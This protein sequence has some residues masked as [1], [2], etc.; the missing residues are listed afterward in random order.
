[1][2]NNRS[3]FSD[4]YLRELVRGDPHWNDMLA[5]VVALRQR[6]AE[7]YKRGTPG[8]EQASEAEVERR[9]IRPV[10]DALAHVYEAQPN[11]RSAE[12]TKTPDYGIFV[13]V[14]SRVLKAT[15]RS[16]SVRGSQAVIRPVPRAPTVEGRQWPRI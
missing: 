11:V 15:S 6:V 3:L 1:L 4:Y 10:L 7:V 12:G 14:R 16:R 2:Y 9:L 8:I 13:G 5:G